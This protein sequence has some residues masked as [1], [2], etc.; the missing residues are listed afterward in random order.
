MAGLIREIG[1]GDEIVCRGEYT[2]VTRVT[3]YPPGHGRKPI[4][5]DWYAIVIETPRGNRYWG[6]EEQP[7]IG[8]DLRMHWS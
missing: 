5:D 2:T 8:G 7:Y 4:R 6:S 3:S 1:P